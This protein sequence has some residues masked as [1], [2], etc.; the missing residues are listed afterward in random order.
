MDVTSPK[1][2]TEKY[3]KLVVNKITNI[4]EEL[5]DNNIV[6][7]KVLKTLIDRNENDFKL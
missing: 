3:T 2:L 4:K 7:E 1:I 6:A 5:P